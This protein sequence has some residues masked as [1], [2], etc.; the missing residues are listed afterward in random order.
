MLWPLQA[1]ERAAFAFRRAPAAGL[2]HEHAWLPLHHR[3][4]RTVI[5]QALRGRWR[6]D[7]LLD[8]CRHL[9]NARAPNVGVDAVADLH[10]GRCFRRRA[11]DTNVPAAARG[12]CRRT[13]LVDPDGPQPNVYPGRVDGAIVPA[14]TD[15][16]WSRLVS[17]TCA[18]E[19]TD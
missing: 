8:D 4:R 3:R 12:C 19:W 1:I 2:P 18:Y 17:A 9:E 10:V 15:G 7:A 5:D 13:G 14:S 6:P 11:V 16:R